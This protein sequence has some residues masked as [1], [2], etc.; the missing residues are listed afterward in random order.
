MHRQLRGTVI[1]DHVT[2]NTLAEIGL[3]GIHALI[4]QLLDLALEPFARIRIGEVHQTH[5][6]LPEVGLPDLAIRLPDQVTLLL[7]FLEHGAAL[8]DIRV[9]PRADMQALVLVQTLEGRFD[10]AEEPLIPFEIGP[11]KLA[12]PI[13]VVVESAQRDV[14]FG[15]AV[16]EGVDGLL[17]VLGGERG[18]QPQ[19]VAPGR[20]VGGAAHQ[21]G[22]TVEDLLG[23]RAID[24][25]EVDGFAG[26]GELHGLRVLGTDLERDVAAVVHQHAIAVRGHVERNILIPL[27][28]GGAAI[29]VPN[30]DGLAVLHIRAEALAE[31]VNVLAD[32]E[33]QLDAGEHVGFVVCGAIHGHTELADRLRGDVGQLVQRESAE[34]LA[35][36]FGEHLAVLVEEGQVPR[37]ALDHLG[38]QAAGGQR[39]A[40]TVLAHFAIAVAVR[41]GVDVSAVARLIGVQ[42]ESGLV[43]RALP[44][45]GGHA[46]H[47]F[48]GRG[49]VDVESGQV[50]GVV[51]AADH[52]GRGEDVQAFLVLADAELV[53]FACVQGVD[54][55]AGQPVTIGELH[56]CCSW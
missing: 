56:C 43:G 33:M 7:A 22:V 29:L 49:H 47:A 14:A 48:G 19:A 13:A 2:R 26:N 24:H 25:A 6:R 44:M 21:R 16:D 45:A 36:G 53:G 46:D 8:A 50:E 9:D 5:A 10:I 38:G 28:G 55:V 15:H 18:G 42:R 11:M 23:G 17:V 20:H 12:H 27:L 31:T 37:R 40:R 51:T 39:D 35:G 52:R 4:Q 54:A 41:V 32:A 3:D 1:P 30:V 34:R